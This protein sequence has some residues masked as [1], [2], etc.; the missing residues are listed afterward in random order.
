MR[1]GVADTDLGFILRCGIFPP[2]D[3]CCH[4]HRAARADAPQADMSLM[5]MP[6]LYLNMGVEMFY[7]INDRRGANWLR[8]LKI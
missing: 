3:R 7:V 6:V 2:A 5:S 1:V 4:G 8:F